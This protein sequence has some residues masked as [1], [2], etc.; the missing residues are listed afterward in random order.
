MTPWEDDPTLAA[1]SPATAGFAEL[2]RSADKVVSST[3]L[4]RTATSRTRLERAFDPA[5][6][7]RLKDTADRDLELVDQHRFEGGTVLL[8]CRVRTAG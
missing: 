4:T 7:Q 2:W 6:A 3:T 5:A 1:S 8:R